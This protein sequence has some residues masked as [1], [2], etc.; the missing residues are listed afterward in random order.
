MQFQNLYVVT[1]NTVIPEI[2][3]WSVNLVKTSDLNSGPIKEIKLIMANSV[4]LD[5]S[6]GSTP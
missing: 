1:F 4:Y 5:E 3:K 6:S 2:F